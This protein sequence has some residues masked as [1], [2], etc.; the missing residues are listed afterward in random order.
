[1]Y[2]FVWTF[3]GLI[4]DFDRIQLK[5]IDADTCTVQRPAAFDHVW[6]AGA[7]RNG[8]PGEPMSNIHSNNI[9]HS[10]GWLQIAWKLLQGLQYFYKVLPCDAQSYTAVKPT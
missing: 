4:F 5:V 7:H 6:T 10:V 1:M 8:V 3:Y 2:Q 9:Q